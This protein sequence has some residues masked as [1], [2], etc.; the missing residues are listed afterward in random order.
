MRDAYRMSES[1]EG[2][3]VLEDPNID[4]RILL[5]FMFGKR[6]EGLGWIPNILWQGL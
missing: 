1:Q 4:G 2:R 6:C 5:K 3:D